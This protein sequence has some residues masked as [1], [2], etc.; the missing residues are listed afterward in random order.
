MSP[1]R[2]LQLGLAL[3][4][5]SAGPI[6]A[7]TATLIA[8][9]EAGW[10]QFRGPRRDGISDEKG[11]LRAWPDAGPR[12]LWTATGA[13]RGFSSTIIGGGR[14]YVTGDFEAE[15]RILAYSLDGQ[16]LWSA[17]NGDAWLNQYQGARASV[18]YRDGRL[19]HQN[20]H[21]RLACLDA[22]TGR[23]L[24]AVDLLARFRGENITWGLSECLL[25]DD[26]AVCS[27]AGGRDALIVAFDRTTGTLLWQSAALP[28]DKD[29]SAAETASYAAPILVQFA[30]RRLII[31]CG[32]RTLYCADADTGKLQWTRPRPTNYGVLAMAP[33]LVGDAIFMAA[34]HGAPGQLYELIAPAQPGDPVGVRDGWTNPIDTCQGGIVHVGG[35]LYG[36][37]YPRR[38]GWAA[39]DARTGA[40]LYET[41]A[42]AKGSTLFADGRLVTLAED[43]WML[44]L[45]PTETKFEVRGRFRLP[46]TNERTRDAWAHPVIH[47]GRLYLRYHDTVVCYDIRAT[48]P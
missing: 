24:W 4:A 44:L 43:G 41:D 48:A 11:L 31:G 42:F 40:T 20:A 39:I 45:E 37:T 7:A 46:G 8:S 33:V 6:F 19:Y 25:V 26:R 30:G 10:P 21:G 35:R 12:L 13:G 34:P 16:P 2:L 1:R 28:S 38:G 17:R 29:A 3:L 27:T 47:Q 5:L 22:A 32:N 23:E 14:L 15:V 9:P 36:S 18:T